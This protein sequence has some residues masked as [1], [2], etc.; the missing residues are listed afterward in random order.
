LE[1]LAVRRIN[2]DILHQLW[3]PLLFFS[4]KG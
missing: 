4:P 2:E 1:W 3:F